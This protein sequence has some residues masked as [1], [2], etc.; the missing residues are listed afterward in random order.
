LNFLNWR[1]Y[2]CVSALDF[3]KEEDFRQSI[4]HMVTLNSVSDPHRFYV[5]PDPAFLMNADPDPDP[6]GRI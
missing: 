4:L 1:P 6:T 5:D 3:S 2:G